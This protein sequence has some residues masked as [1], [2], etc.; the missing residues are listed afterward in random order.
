MAVTRTQ[1]IPQLIEQLGEIYDHSV[2]ALRS[3]LAR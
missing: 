2:A 3:A 1:D